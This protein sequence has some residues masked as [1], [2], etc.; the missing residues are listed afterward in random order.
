RRPEVQEH[1]AAAIR[2]QRNRPPRIVLEREIFG[3]DGLP[4]RIGLEW[5]AHLLLLARDLGGQRAHP[6]VGEQPHAQHE[7]DPTDGQLDRI[8]RA[9]LRRSS[10]SSTRYLNALR[11]DTK[12][13]GISVRKRSINAG[14]PSMSIS[15]SSNGTSL[16]T[17]A[18]TC[19]AS[20][21][22]QQS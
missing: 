4:A 15:A 20:S 16:R 3:W 9:T 6:F 19:F 18:S 17:R 8:H 13:T 11:P 10:V 5:L 14:S 22:R 1:D 21:Q 12:I 2:R 7:H